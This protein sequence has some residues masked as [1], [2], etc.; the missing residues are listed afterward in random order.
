LGAKIEEM[1]EK[2][3][4]KEKMKGLLEPYKRAFISYATK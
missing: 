1:K 2:K 4:R 3:K